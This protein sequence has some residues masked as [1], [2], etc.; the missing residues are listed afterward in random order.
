MA[1]KKTNSTKTEVQSLV[2]EYMKKLVGKPSSVKE[3]REEMS[4]EDLMKPVSVP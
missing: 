1:K 4:W 3:I 2:E